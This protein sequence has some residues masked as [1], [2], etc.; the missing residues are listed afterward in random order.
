MELAT[1]TGFFIKILENN[2]SSDYVRALLIFLGLFIFFKVF[3][4]SIMFMLKKV[5]EKTKNN[6]DDFLIDFIDSLHWPFYVYLAVYFSA[7]TLSLPEV[8]DQILNIFL[9][10]FVIFYIAKGLVN[11]SNHFLDKYGEKRKAKGKSSKESMIGVLKLMSTGTIW[12]VAVLMALSN[13]GIE[14]TPLIAGLGIGGLAV[15]LAL[16]GI[17]GDLFS[18]FTIYFD[19]PFEEGDFIIIG[20]DMG[21]IK[22][23]GIKSTRIQA[24][25]GQEL[26]IS[27][28]ELTSTRVNNY[29]KMDTRRVV[30]GF[31]LEYK[32]SV[33][34]LEK[35]KKIV[36]GVVKKEKHSTLDRVHFKG[37]GDSSL[38]FEVVYYV[39]S[40]DYN[41]YMDVQ[42]KINLGIKGLIEK[43]GVSFAFPSRTVYTKKG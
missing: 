39:D 21:T 10:I 23:I 33:A 35:I 11:V 19:K 29:K 15:G 27:N 14:I 18:A 42:E 17:L 36:E 24:L 38:D 20:D 41:I 4:S 32:T 7:L 28:S 6:I 30:F 34:K 5:K 40:N 26:V 9:L 22:H 16:Q 25:G 1:I 12:T 13:L 43:E 37:F 2:N 31:G 3:N 8:L